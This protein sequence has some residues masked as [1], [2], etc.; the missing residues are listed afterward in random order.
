M[1]PSFETIK[2][3]IMPPLDKNFQPAVL[4]NRAF[5]QEAEKIGVPCRT[6]LRARGPADFE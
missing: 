4:V 3:R 6:Q 1:I 2:P 5:R